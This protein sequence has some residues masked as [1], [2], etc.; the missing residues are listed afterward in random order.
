MQGISENSRLQGTLIDKSAP[1]DSTPTLKPSFIQESTRSSERHTTIILQQSR[2]TTLIIKKWTAESHARPIETPKLTTGHFI[3]LQTEEIQFHRPEHRH[4]LPQS[5]NLDKPVAQPHPE[6]ED[7]TIKR[8]HK[9]L[10]CRK[11]T[12]NTTMKQMK[13]QRNLTGE[14]A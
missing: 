2:N 12:P 14:G 9:L 1:K 4:R 11:G 6:E 7:S 3:A 10:H 13:R 8:N 5:G